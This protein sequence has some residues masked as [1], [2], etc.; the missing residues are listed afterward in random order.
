MKNW[1]QV[2]KRGTK[3][4]WGSLTPFFRDNGLLINYFA[5]YS[6]KLGL[7]KLVHGPVI[8]AKFPVY[9][10]LSVLGCCPH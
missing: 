8:A 5:N 6:L 7:A 3:S 4:A 9:P 1:A 2:A 10:E